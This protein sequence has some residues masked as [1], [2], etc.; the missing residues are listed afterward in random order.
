MK[1]GIVAPFQDA[2]GYCNFAIDFTLGADAGGVDVVAQR[3]RLANQSVEPPARIKELESKPRNGIDILIQSYLPV[4]YYYRGGMKNGCLLHT[5]TT[6][7][8]ISAWQFHINLMDFVL[9][10][11]PQSADCLKESGVTKPIYVV[12]KPCNPEIYTK[13]YAPLPIP[14][15]GKY[16]FYHI[17][18]YSSR[19]NI[20]AL[21]KGYLE[22]FDVED[23]VVLVLKTYLEGKS[24]K[25]SEEIIAGEI[26]NIKK[27]LRK[28]AD[29]KWYPPIILITDYLSDEAIWR[30]H[31][32][33]DCFVS[34]ERGAS[35]NIPAF[36]AAAFGNRVIVNGWGGQTQF[37]RPE[38]GVLLDY[39][40]IPVGGMDQ[41]PYQ[42]LYSCKEYWAEPD[43]EQAKFAM[44]LAYANKLK[45][46]STKILADWSYSVAG[47]KIKEVLDNV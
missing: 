23:N 24:G 38:N 6:N 43:I 10:A 40:M 5:E 2:T 14:T 12:P 26:A 25:E 1:T 9:V 46:D 19:K 33:C 42:M 7:I 20:Q 29:I 27:N 32:Q 31:Q 15:G 47:K 18:D 8:R 35:F 36:D 13:T 16:V 39:K 30:L 41:C 11:C 17:G 44:R 22:E 28:Y 37:I 45:G 21:I 34:L 4:M 3:I